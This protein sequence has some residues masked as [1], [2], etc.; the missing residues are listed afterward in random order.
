[1]QYP[2]GPTGKKVFVSGPDLEARLAV[3]EKD[4]QQLEV[5]KHFLFRDSLLKYPGSFTKTVSRP[6]R[7]E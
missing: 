5:S 3:V 4:E 7:F 1:M 6:R 2:D